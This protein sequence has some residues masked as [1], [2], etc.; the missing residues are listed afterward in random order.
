MY[1]SN[2]IL[3]N[4]PIVQTLREIVKWLNEEIEFPPFDVDNADLSLQFWKE[5]VAEIEKVTQT[6]LNFVL[7]LVDMDTVTD[8][9]FYGKYVTSVADIDVYQIGSIVL[10]EVGYDGT[11]YGYSDKPQPIATYD[12]IIKKRKEK[13]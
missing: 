6:P 13:N 5:V 2:T 3:Q 11:L 8:K 12:E 1:L 9:D 4:S 7:W 10:A